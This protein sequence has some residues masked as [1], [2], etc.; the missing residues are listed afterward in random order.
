[1]LALNELAE[2]TELVLVIEELVSVDWVT[3]MVHQ[4]VH[5]VDP[6]LSVAVF[7]QEFTHLADRILQ[8]PIDVR[9]AKDVHH[10]TEVTGAADEDRVGVNEVGTGHRQITSRVLAWVQRTT[11]PILILQH[12]LLN[13]GILHHRERTVVLGHDGCH[14]L[15]DLTWCVNQPLFDIGA[16]RVVHL[17]EVG[18]GVTFG[19]EEVVQGVP[20]VLQDGH[21]IRP[22]L[23]RE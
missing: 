21:Q 4:D 10:P 14:I 17:K 15:G 7:R 18:A 6:H 8:L 12:F 20:P 22:L 9:R 5:P 2:P 13:L 16:L 1:V 11:K 3:R 19:G 23:V